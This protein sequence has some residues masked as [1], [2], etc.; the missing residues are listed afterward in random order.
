M[1]KPARR[2][3]DGL[4]AADTLARLH[5]PNRLLHALKRVLLPLLNS[6]LRDRVA[7]GRS[8]ANRVERAKCVARDASK[9]KHS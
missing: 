8:V 5:Q 2:R 4:A 1:V 6:A 9:D 3:C 7:R